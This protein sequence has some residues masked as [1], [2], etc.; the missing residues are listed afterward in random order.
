MTEQQ[1]D[2]T[3]KAR[4]FVEK[5][6]FN[7]AGVEALAARNLPPVKVYMNVKT[8]NCKADGVELQVSLYFDMVWKN[9]VPTSEYKLTRNGDKMLKGKGEPKYVAQAVDAV[10]NN[11]Q[12]P[13][14]QEF[15]DD[16]PF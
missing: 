11:P 15:D 9:G 7:K 2:P 12:P 4:V 6:I 8:C 3:N 10:K 1:F 13:T 5:G 16:I 14:G